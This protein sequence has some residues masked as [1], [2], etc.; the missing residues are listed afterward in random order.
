MLFILGQTLNYQIGRGLTLYIIKSYTCRIDGNIG[1]IQ[2]LHHQLCVIQRL[3]EYAFSLGKDNWKL[4]MPLYTVCR[5]KFPELNSKVLQNFLRFHFVT[6]K[7]KPKHKVPHASIIIDY[8][9]FGL[10]FDETTKLTNFWLR[11]HRK[12]FI[13]LGKFLL[14]RIYNPND[15]KLV[16]IYNKN[17]R[18]YCKLTIRTDKAIKDLSQCN[19]S[20]GLDVNAK[21]IVLSNNNFYNL[22][23][24]YHRKMEHRKNKQKHHNLE[25]YTNDFLHKITT[26]ISKDLHKNGLEVLVMEN[27]RNMRHSSSKKL[28]TSKGKKIN[29]IV[30]SLPYR[31]IQSL[32]EYKCLE[33]GINVVYIDSAYTSTICSS[34]GS[35]NTKRHKT[36]FR[37]LDCGLNL[38][39]DLNGS[40]NICGRYTGSNGLPVNPAQSLP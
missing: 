30:N 5:E 39:A 6:P 4:L 13:L 31:K 8:Q 15:L 34:C 33:L 26:K 2:Y 38:D 19:K 32:L 14:N 7:R 36:S 12:N 40:R 23:K 28:G 9:S 25:N 3:S 29:Y 1:K 17:N 22:K 18:L 35:I 10:I 16:Q 37:C 11:F 24:L 27:L 20:I 21:R